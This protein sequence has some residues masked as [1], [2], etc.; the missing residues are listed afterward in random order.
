MKAFDGKVVV[1]TGATSGIGQAAAIAF[2][3][4]GASV[5]VSGRREA[6]GL[7]TVR[8]VE[9]TG[10]KAL[11]VAADVSDE[12]QVENLV[13]KTVAA[14][15][16]IDAAFLNS[17]VWMFV[18]LTEATQQDFDYQT[19]INYK[20]VWLALKHFA[21]VMLKNENGGAFVI[22][23]SAVAEVGMAGTGLYAGSK[24]A[25]VA[26]AR[27]AAIEMAAQ[28]V[29]VNVVNPGPIAT[30]AATHSFGG[31]KAANEFFGPKIPMGRIG[32]PE[33]IA[34]VA[35]FLASDAASYITGQSLN[36]DGGYTAQ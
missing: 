20:G 15:G 26:L 10:A 25:V 22:N 21:P 2:G 23:A 12:A 30:H 27:S 19:N 9:A 3:R 33:E 14:F 24:G 34:D 32:Q 18:P 7:E 4:E 29:R 6:E 1:V 5:V 11:W 31:A 36:V 16:R 28:K 17:G 8:Q 13:Q 35:V